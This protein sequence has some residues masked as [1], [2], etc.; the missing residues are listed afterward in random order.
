[1]ALNFMFANGVLIPLIFLIVISFFIIFV[2]LSV[3]I[4]GLNFLRLSKM[5]ASNNIYLAWRVI[6]LSF[7]LPLV[8]LESF[9]T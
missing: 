6:F 2:Y 3:R 5:G 4:I 7:W 9:N 8:L 1:M